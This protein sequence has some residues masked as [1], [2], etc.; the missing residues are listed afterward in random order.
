MNLYTKIELFLNKF[1]TII[2]I[3]LSSIFL[4]IIMV[5]L[6]DILDENMTF[7]FAIFIIS[8]IIIYYFT[9]LSLGKESKN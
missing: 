2:G 4:L 1:P 5:L 3:Y 8:S 6:Q 9:I 7:I